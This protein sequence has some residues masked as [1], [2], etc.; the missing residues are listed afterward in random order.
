[1]NKLQNET[2]P[3]LLQHKDN[4]VNWYPWGDEAL[5]LAKSQDKPIL[6]SVGYSACHW[7]H[8][9]AHESFEHDETAKMMNEWFINIKVD[10]EERPDVDSIY[11][12]AVQAMAGRGGWP[13]T[14]F[15]L[16]DGRPFYGGTYYPLEPRYGM[17]S[18]RDVLRGVYDAYVNRRDELATMAGNLTQALNR[19]VLGIGGDADALNADLLAQA[20]NSLRRDYDKTYGGFSGAPKFPQPMV[21]EFVL[22]YAVNTD[23]KDALTM[24]THTLTEMARGGIY[25]QIGGGFARYSVDALWLVPH[26]EKM[27]YDNAQLSRL[28][29]H[30]WQ[31][32]QDPFFLRIATEI[33]DYLL[34]EMT[35]PDGGFY[36][37]TDADS[38]GEEGKFFVW[39]I[40]ELRD[41]LDD[42]LYDTAIE[43]F[44]VTKGGNFE[45]HNILT[46]PNPSDVSA[47]RLN[48]TVEE[49]ENR[50]ALI[51]DKLYTTRLQRIPPGLDD[52]ILTGWNGMAL[53]SLAEAA[54]ILN[55]AD[56]RQAAVRC[57]TFLAEKLMTDGYHLYRTH[58]NGVSKLNGYLEDYANLIDAF[59][60]MYQLTFDEMWFTHAINL[61]DHTLKH[62]R[63]TDGG[64]FDTRD[65][66]EDL[67]VRPRTVQ[68]N[69]VP[70]GNNMMAKQLLRLY[71]YTGNPLYQ[72]VAVGAVKLLTNAL[73]QYPHGFGEALNTVDMLARGV[74]EI[75]IIGDP[76]SDQT[77]ALLAEIYAKYRPNSVLALSPV[78]VGDEGAIPL[79]RGRGL[80]GDMP[81]V[82]VCRE[83]TC[84]LPVNT[85]DELRG[86]LT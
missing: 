46:L 68:D 56:Y 38:E 63:A 18:F 51:K 4:P 75:A 59:I 83:F 3:Y 14:V 48:I 36:S 45:G 31:A 76:K 66:H 22:R 81:T 17:P 41:L 42:P 70:S 16:P 52:K 50:V 86:M 79:L 78:A 28:Y 37:A 24:V 7:C 77:Q 23:D 47:E 74:D 60:E 58:K 27:L 30:T 26:F 9:M 49:L 29:L 44:G 11:M 2:S 82:Y 67:I 54:R 15:L 85:V 19:V 57:A 8:V 53:A 33:D 34:R 5:S 43:V 39:S 12:E 84:K 40:A 55:R 10:R 64:F 61:A 65:D 20:V 25:D 32:T 6:L 1:M 62:F 71:A 80:K 69:A 73:G 13:M 21:W 35:S 72:E